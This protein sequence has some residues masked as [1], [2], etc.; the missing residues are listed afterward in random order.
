MGWDAP[1]SGSRAGWWIALSTFVAALVAVAALWAGGAA[2]IDDAG[3]SAPAPSPA[4]RPNRL[5]PLSIAPGHIRPR[6]VLYGDSLAWES[7]QSFAFTLAAAGADVQARTW[8]GTAICDFF[9]T[10]RKD[11]AEMH[12]DAVVVEF[13]GNAFSQC[14]RSRAPMTGDEPVDA[15]RSDA[16]EVL[17]I[18]PK[19]RVYFVGAPVGAPGKPGEFHPGSLNSM[20]RNQAVRHPSARYVDA[21]AAVLDH[22]R[23]TKT[24]PCLPHEPCTG[25]RDSHGRRVNVVRAPDGTHFCPNA[26]AAEFGV[27]QACA[28]WSSGAF[29]FGTAMSKAVAADFPRSGR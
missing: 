5:E 21:G 15:Y 13:I 6:V 12:P 22:G 9:H 18:F 14:M 20:Y 16:Q 26:A 7:R 25:G 24:L 23:W 11:A 2:A 3:G 29:R 19:A 17:R 10:M 28:V 1:N 4:A 8:G 27:T